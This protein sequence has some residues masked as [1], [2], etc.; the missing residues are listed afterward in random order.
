MI[1]DFH[2]YFQFR[3][4]R[5]SFSKHVP[6]ELLRGEELAAFQKCPVFFLEQRRLEKLLRGGPLLFSEMS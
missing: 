2:F 1:T 5:D 4:V 6:L 3:F